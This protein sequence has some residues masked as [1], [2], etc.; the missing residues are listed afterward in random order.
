MQSLDRVRII[1]WLARHRVVRDARK[2]HEAL[3]LLI[4][5]EFRRPFLSLLAVV[6]LA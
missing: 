1:V 2:R 5:V 6:P 3:D 4:G